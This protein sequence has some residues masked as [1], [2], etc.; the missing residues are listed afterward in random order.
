MNR[1]VVKLVEHLPAMPK[2]FTS[3]PTTYER[4]RREGEEKGGTITRKICKID[5]WRLGKWLTT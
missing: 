4:E 1:D 5:S 3:I 2:T